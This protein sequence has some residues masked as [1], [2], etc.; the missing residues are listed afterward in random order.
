MA[1]GARTFLQ[2]RVRKMRT[3]AIRDFVVLLC[4]I[5]CVHV[6]AVQF[7]THRGDMAVERE[8]SLAAVKRAHAYGAKGCEIDVRMRHDGVPAL[9]H[10]ALEV[11]ADTLE[12]V[13]AYM[14]KNDMFPLLD[15]KEPKAEKLALEMVRRHGLAGKT[16]SI[17]Y[18][19]E[20]A[21]RQKSLEPDMS[22]FILL[23]R[24]KGESDDAYFARYEEAF[25]I[26][27][28]DGAFL[29]TGSAAFAARFHAKGYRT[30][31]GS[32][33]L[34]G[35]SDGFVEQADFL[36]V[37]DPAFIG[38]HSG[39]E[40]DIPLREMDAA[41]E[42]RLVARELSHRG[43]ARNAP[44]GSPK[45]FTPP[46]DEVCDRQALVW[47]EDHDPL[48]VLLRRT[49]ALA[50]DL[51]NAVPAGFMHDLKRLE[52]LA[53]SV[54][55]MDRDVRY[56]IFRKVMAVRRK[57]AFSN[58]LV[59]A[60]DRLLFITREALPPD[61]F[62]WG[63]HMC[64]QFFGFHATQKGLV[65]GNGLFVLDRP[66][67]SGAPHAREIACG[68]P[69][70]SGPWKGRQLSTNGGFLSP[71]L[72]Y[73]GK[74]ILFSYTTGRS[75][76]RT[77]NEHTTF[78]IF[79]IG[80]DGSNLRMLTGGDKNDLFPCWMPNGRIVFCSERRGGY[81][82]CHYRECP[83]FTLHAMNADG[84]G[85]ECLS[86][87]ETN[88]WEPSI[89]NNG[90]IVYT[91]WDYVD[92]G[93]NQAHHPW[94][95]YPDGRDPREFSGNTRKN[96][97]AGPHFVQSIRA[98]P[99]SRK[100]VAT[101]CGHHTLARG[102]LIM[103]DPSVPDDDAM[104][105]IKRI[106]PDQLMPESEFS[107]WSIRH[108]GAYGS[109]WPLSERY[110]LCIYDGDANGQYGPIDCRRR[111]Y[112]ITLVD[113][114]G[115]KIRIYRNPSISCMEPIPLRPRMRPPIIPSQ[116]VKGGKSTIACIDV[117]NS[118]YPFPDGAVPKHLRI[119]QVL[120]KVQPIVGHP[121]LGVVDQTPGRQC[122][123][124]V[125]VESDGSVF[126]EAPANVPLFFQ[127]LDS[128]GCAI[129]TMRSATYVRSGERLACNG[130]HESRHGAMRTAPNAT[131]GAVT[132]MKRA[133][134]SIEPEV[135]GSCPYNYPRLVQGVLDRK[136]VSCH[137]PGNAKFDSAK[138]PNLA[139]G[140]SDKNPYGFH[141][142]FIELVGLGMVQYYS[143]NYKGRDWVKK[144]VQR[145]AFTFAY[146]EP[147]KIG[148]RGSRLY[149]I[150]KKGHHDVTLSPEE[151]RRLI[152]FMDS[153]G[154]YLAHDH[155]PHQQLE[156]K[157][158]KPILE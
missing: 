129:Q 37:D 74:T 90:M 31:Y 120:P 67:G 118:R 9:G 81:G 155:E 85:I 55:F 33:T 100:Y 139:K 28:A 125:P 2:E 38:D 104:S 121:R 158:V 127:V 17:V 83:N 40:Q 141:T 8:N 30:M 122:L 5:A 148:A 39:I 66:F 106:T 126:F 131:S 142:S 77:W 136:C 112:A 24:Q 48:D 75:L 88:E 151:W 25:R 15:V 116:I 71:D 21:K 107:D 89:D 14:A 72:S 43:R 1:G 130:C 143:N 73:D 12:S 150:L 79:S 6:D 7:I 138:M 134:S 22:P 11:G 87:H 92:R 70:A 82:R 18:T 146:S 110:F 10:A 64:D 78:H 53:A 119:W 117:A 114:F 16:M 123:G 52:S 135:E 68:K 128:D 54:Y 144:G 105:T 115:N 62:D 76:V 36:I 23:G 97:H 137:S 3:K 109:P 84:G 45:T 69:I 49:R 4:A 51:G 27:G 145:D 42:W 29:S 13:L 94:M 99:G 124:T 57:I 149:S 63:V 58:P 32:F 34:P 133:P 19:A 154:A 103:I 91:R 61:E 44:A 153:H 147:G 111:N 93:F 59:K 140:D 60:I 26:S 20:D 86:P 113:V 80:T 96:E 50:D 108:S 56:D 101:A 41:T 98:I 157:I 102:S 35:Q 156:G 47:A 95:V 132:A 65:K 46:E 152:L